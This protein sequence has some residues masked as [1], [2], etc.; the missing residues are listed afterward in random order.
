M[1]G[2]K[3]MLEVQTRTHIDEDV[4]FVMCADAVMKS[5]SIPVVP[6]VDILEFLD[7]YLVDEYS[8]QST[9]G[10]VISLDS[11]EVPCCAEE[12][13]RCAMSCAEPQVEGR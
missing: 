1:V 2:T 12:V 7:E 6:E 11:A 3:N 10:P 5:P 13:S 4:P 9:E 8:E